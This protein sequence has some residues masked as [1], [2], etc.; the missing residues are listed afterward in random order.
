VQDAE[1][2]ADASLECEFFGASIGN[3]IISDVTGATRM[4]SARDSERIPAQW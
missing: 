1:I 3:E 2:E 4:S